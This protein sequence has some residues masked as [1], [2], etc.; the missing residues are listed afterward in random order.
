MLSRVPLTP[1]GITATEATTAID[2]L[3]EEGVRVLNFS[4]HSPTL[5]PGHTPYVRS[6]DD[7][8]R[9]LA[10]R[11]FYTDGL[12]TLFAFGAVYAA[13]AFGMTL[14]EVILFGIA[15]NATAGLGAAGFGM[16]E[17]RVGS[18]RTVVIALVALMAL[19]AGL[20]VVQGKTGFWVLALML[21]VFVGPAQAAS[22][23]LMARMAPPEEV[24]AHFGLFALSALPLN[25]AGAA[26]MLPGQAGW[27]GLLVLAA[28]TG[29]GVVTA[30]E[31][32]RKPA[33]LWIH[34]RATLNRLR[35]LKRDFAA[36]LGELKKEWKIPN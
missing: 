25:H 36:K 26:L 16:V 10:A 24:G 17:D 8:A 33:E 35:D 9:F 13:G 14:D 20:L 6:E 22:R 29:A 30:L 32:L 34:E 23:T 21:G 5:E 2:A 1:E 4:F 18:K 19:S 15:L 11:L 12:N 28:S 31:G 27:I 7:L 3:I